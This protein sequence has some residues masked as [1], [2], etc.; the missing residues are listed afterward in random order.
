M[1]T[2]LVCVTPAPSNSRTRTPKPHPLSE[3][4][5]SE[6]AKDTYFEN[7]VHETRSRS[8]WLGRTHRIIAL[9]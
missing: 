6:P 9:D 8:S 7:E 4:H 5:E 2:C 3:K 1:A